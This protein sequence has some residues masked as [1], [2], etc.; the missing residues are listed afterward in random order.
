MSSSDRPRF[1]GAFQS[2]LLHAHVC[3][4]VEPDGF[5]VD[6]WPHD[7]LPHLP[8]G[9][10]PI[11]VDIGSFSEPPNADRHLAP[12]RGD[13]GPWI[14]VVGP[15]GKAGRCR[16]GGAPS[17][18]R[19]VFSVPAQG[20]AL[21]CAVRWGWVAA[22]EM[23]TLLAVHRAPSLHVGLRAA[24]RRIVRQRPT[25]YGRLERYGLNSSCPRMPNGTLSWLARETGLSPGHLSLL[26]RRRSLDLRGMNDL[27]RTLL[28]VIL[29]MEEGCWEKAAW[30]L[31][32]SG[33]AGLNALFRRSL[34]CRPRDLGY[35]PGSG[36]KRIEVFLIGGITDSG[37][38]RSALYER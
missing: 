10:G 34:G 32:F 4:L 16:D 15:D 7:A 2:G 24:L 12:G 37:G 26:S 22:L 29:H 6:P 38:R 3:G 9:S 30:R 5:R 19:S 21:L 23:R 11:L 25:E 35:M 20:K 14:G 33:G 28:A 8:E 27:W 18:F 17:G 13:L 1:F 31:G 36:L